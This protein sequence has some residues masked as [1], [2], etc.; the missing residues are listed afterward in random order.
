MSNKAPLFAVILLAV[1]VG[2]GLTKVV[3]SVA[4]NCFTRS[5]G[6]TAVTR[7]LKGG[8]S[9]DA[10]SA[11]WRQGR[12][13]PTLADAAEWTGEQAGGEAIKAILQIATLPTSDRW[14]WRPPPV[15][16]YYNPSPPM[17]VFM[18]PPPPPMPVFEPPP[19]IP[20]Y[21]PPP[22]VTPYYPY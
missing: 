21:Q 10:V 19:P 4:K 9:D 2:A 3:R 14:D 7:A 11:A 12:S 22:P 1:P 6:K 20:V 13:G 8:A 17:P 18:P 15:P 16:T 5:G